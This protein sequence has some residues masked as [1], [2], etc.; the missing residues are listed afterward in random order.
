M[1][2]SNK[3]PNEI[4]VFYMHIQLIGKNMTNFLTLLSGKANPSKAKQNLEERKKIEDFWDF[5]YSKDKE[6]KEQIDD[7]YQHLLD[8]KNQNNPGKIKETLVFKVDNSFDMSVEYIFQKL[9]DLREDYYMPILLF[10]VVNEKKEITYDEKKYPKIKKNLIISKKYSEDPKYYQEDGYM[11]NLFIRFCSIHNELGERFSIGEGE[12]FISYDLIEKYFPFNLNLCCIGRFGQ[13]KSTGVNVILNE[14]KAKESSQGSAQTKYLTF[15]QVSNAPIR[16]LDI[17]GFDSEQNVKNAVQKL[18]ECSEE[19]N[20]L[21]D[22]IHFFLYFLSEKE[23]RTFSQYESPIIEEIIKYKDAKVI[24]VVTHSEKDEEEEEKEEFIKKINQGIYGLK[25]ITEDKKELVK[26][27]MTAS[28]ENVVFVNFYKQKK[29]EEFG[30]KDLFKKIHNFFIKSKFYKEASKNLSPEEVE[31]KAAILKERANSI[32]IWN[33]VTGGLIGAIPG[34][35]WLIHKYVLKNQI[36]NKI[37]GVFGIN[38]NF[39]NE[40][41]DRANKEIKNM[42][43]PGSENKDEN[44]IYAGADL[45]LEKNGDEVINDCAENKIGNQAKVVGDAGGIIGGISLGIGY[46]KAQAA[47]G[48]VGS[49]RRIIK[50]T[51]AAKIAFGTFAF[52]IGTV[53][54]IGAGAYLTCHECNELINKFEQIYKE[55]AS[56][57][58]NSYLYAADYLALNA[59]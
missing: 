23:T 50:D 22:Y 25:E 38:I 24:Y 55:N 36:I 54:G 59:K 8:L 31:K 6:I 56:K 10:L 15:Y 26:E 47:S 43:V 28:K 27:M 32:L 16:I 48:I 53:I 3:H 46:N 30:K 37:G 11:K 33:K 51:G 5:D 4:D 45:N 29:N 19:I 17:P 57:I 14:Y 13:G 18:S 40:Q 34:L 12:N 41:N 39:I 7:Y 42:N 52:A 20:K 1:G 58:Y 9:N 35:D 44:N 2:N 21:Q 49:A